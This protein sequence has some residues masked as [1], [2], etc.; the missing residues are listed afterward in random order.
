M[1]YTKKLWIA[2]VGTALN[3]FLKTNEDA[4][5]VELT[6]DPTGITTA[7]TPFTVANMNN[8]ETGIKDNDT[9][10]LDNEADNNTQDTAIGLNTTHRGLTN[11]PHSVD[12]DDLDLGTTDDVEFKG[13][14]LDSNLIK[15]RPTFGTKSSFASPST[16]PYGLTFDGTNLI[17]CDKNSNLIY[18]HDG[19]SSTILSSFASPS[20]DPT[21]LTFDGTNLIS[22]DSF[23]N[24]I[25]IHDGISSTILNSFASPGTNPTGLAF[26]GT[27][28]ISCDSY[29]TL[30]YIHDGISSTILNSFAS[31]GNLFGLTF[32]GTNLISCDFSSDLIYIHDGIS[33]TILSSFASPSTGPTGLAFDGPNL[34]SCDSG[35]NLI[36]TN[37]SELIL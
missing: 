21:G 10:S 35:T 34:I 25:Y 4:G 8:I 15:Y 33:S 3:R 9:R 13:L 29:V 22:C 12:K 11:N 28:L 16:N 7:G 14:T 18:I 5:S 24:L 37:Y 6:N 30:I 2:R 23:S 19:I 31:P 20:T 36:Y 32:D 17:S 27:N 26:D 1:A